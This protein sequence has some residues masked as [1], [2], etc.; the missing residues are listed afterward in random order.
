MSDLETHLLRVEGHV[1]AGAQPA[2][3]HQRC[4]QLHQLLL[5]LHH[6]VNSNT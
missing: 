2:A 6:G 3:L 4:Q 1:L 5:V